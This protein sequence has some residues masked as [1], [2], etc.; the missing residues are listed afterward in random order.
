MFEI[1]DSRCF[2]L[3]RGLNHRHPEILPLSQTLHRAFVGTPKILSPD[4]HEALRAHNCRIHDSIN[5]LGI[6]IVSSDFMCYSRLCNFSCNKVD[7]ISADDPE[8]V[9]D[10]EILE[11]DSKVSS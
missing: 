1:I 7:C 2:L 5:L 11:N 4:W 8:R 6:P 9:R 3:V 10:R